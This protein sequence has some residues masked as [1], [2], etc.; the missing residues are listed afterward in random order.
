[1]MDGDG[2][3]GNQM[4]DG[5]WGWLGVAIMIIIVVATVVLVILLLK[6]NMFGRGRHDISGDSPI[7]TIDARF[8]RGEIEEDQRN[9]MIETL[10]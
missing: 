8:A 4:M 5:T 1:M 6:S 2:S 10:S 3:W 7:D 9:R